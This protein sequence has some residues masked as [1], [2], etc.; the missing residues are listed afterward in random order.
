MFDH[1]HQ[2]EQPA[3]T[4]QSGN[5]TTNSTQMNVEEEEKLN[6]FLTLMNQLMFPV[7]LLRDWL[8]LVL[9]RSKWT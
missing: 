3:S 6:A 9:D 1:N 8:L 7:F 4:L 2:P 5:E